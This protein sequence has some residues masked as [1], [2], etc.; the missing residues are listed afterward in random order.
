LRHGQPSLIPGNLAVPSGNAER[1][2][3]RA[4]GTQNYTCQEKKDAPG[5][6]DWAFTA[7]EAEL[8]D[9]GGKKLGTHFAGPT[10]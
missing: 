8:F 4:T 6:F 3:A 2:N 9:A 7:P 5:T 1:F 10:W